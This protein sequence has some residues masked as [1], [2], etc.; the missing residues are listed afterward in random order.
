MA[1]SSALAQGSISEEILLNSRRGKDA[2]TEKVLYPIIA[3][4][5]ATKSLISSLS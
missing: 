2:L 5:F 4:K 3:L 1:C